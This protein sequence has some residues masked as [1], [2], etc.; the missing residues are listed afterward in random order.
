MSSHVTLLPLSARLPP[1]TG[2]AKKEGRGLLQ[3]LAGMGSR[4]FW[5][6]YVPHTLPGG[7]WSPQFL[8]GEG[9]VQKFMNGESILRGS[10]GPPNGDWYP[11]WLPR[12]IEAPTPLS[13]QL[14]PG[15]APAGRRCSAVLA[16]PT[17]IQAVCQPPP[18]RPS[19]HLPG[20]LRPG[21]ERRR[22]GLLLLFL[23]FFSPALSQAPAALETGTRSRGERGGRGKLEDG[24]GEG[25]AGGRGKCEAGVLARWVL[26]PGT[27][28]S[29][30]PPNPHFLRIQRGFPTFPPIRAID[31]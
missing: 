5:M 19:R 13:F 6:P 18:P 29:E 11:K 15:G 30:Q 24:W 31:L 12:I 7:E 26:E 1:T 25:A 14:R 8:N 3:G 23:L 20:R 10:P 17:Q 21:S 16:A 4:N 28:S 22:R 27:S 9:P 2:E